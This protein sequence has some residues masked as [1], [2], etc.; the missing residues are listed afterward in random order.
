MAEDGSA[1][2]AATWPVPPLPSRGVDG[3]GQELVLVGFENNDPTHPVF[4]DATMKLT[5]T[6]K[7]DAAFEGMNATVMIGG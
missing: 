5:G 6:A 1:Q 3:L 2:S 4:L 7:Q